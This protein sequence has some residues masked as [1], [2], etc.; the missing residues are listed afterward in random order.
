MSI[1]GQV[2]GTNGKNQDQSR[3]VGQLAGQLQSIS[4]LLSETNTK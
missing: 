1:T 4:A 3:R 2:G